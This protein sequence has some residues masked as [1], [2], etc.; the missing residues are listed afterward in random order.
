MRTCLT[1]PGSRPNLGIY[2]YPINGTREPLDNP[3][4][5]RALSMAIN[6]VAITEKVLKTGE[7]PAYS[8]VP[9]GTGNYG[10]PAYVGWKDTPYAERVE[11][12]KALL[13]EAGIGPDNPLSLELKYNTSENHKKVAIAVAAMWKPLGVK[14]SLFNSEVKVHYNSLDENDFDVARAGWIADYNDAENFLSLLATAT[15]KQNYGR[16]SNADFD[17]LMK[18]AAATTDLDARADLLRQGRA[19][20]HGRD[21]DHSHLLLRLEEPGEPE[22]PGLVRQHQGHPPRPLH[23]DRRID[24]PHEGVGETSSPTSSNR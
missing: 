8:F 19:D 21:G 7:L 12:A 9:P 11:Q 22:G 5:R 2:Y 13:A 6:R 14:V 4:V 17:R 15:G 16:Y 10:E 23:V 24:Q 20:C 18:E 3:N 1:R